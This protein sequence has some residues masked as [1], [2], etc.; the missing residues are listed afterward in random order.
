MP[1][2]F[3]ARV[4]AFITIECVTVCVALTWPREVGYVGA[5]IIA[6]VH[7]CSHGNASLLPTF[8]TYPCTTGEFVS[9]GRLRFACLNSGVALHHFSGPAFHMTHR[10]RRVPV[11]AVRC[12]VVVADY[13]AI[14]AFA[15]YPRERF[16]ERSQRVGRSISLC[17]CGIVV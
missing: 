4:C 3:F 5:Q 2:A 12:R 11:G 10:Q 14:H 8:Y 9:R 1:E 15:L 7:S 16:D 6:A 13:E 17:V